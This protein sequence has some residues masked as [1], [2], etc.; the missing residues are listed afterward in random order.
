MSPGGARGGRHET[1]TLDS[2]KGHARSHDN[3]PSPEIS[4]EQRPRVK[5]QEGAS[6]SDC[7]GKRRRR[8]KPNSMPW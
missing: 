4:R 2:G 8:G 6:R 7:E 3:H 1:P 5:K